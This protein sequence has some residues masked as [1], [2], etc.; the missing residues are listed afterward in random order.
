MTTKIG[1][2]TFS[3]A[4]CASGARG[5]FGEGYR[6]HRPLKPFG[7]DWR[8]STFAAKTMTLPK[9]AGNM[10]LLEDYTPKEFYP[11]CIRVNFF[12]GAPLNAVGL[13]NPGAQALLE[14]GKFQKIPRPFQLSFMAVGLTRDE[15]RKEVEGFGRLL[16]H[17]LPGF[18]SKIALQLNYSCPNL[19]GHE[20]AEEELIIEIAEDLAILGSYVDVL[21]VIKLSSATSV[22]TVLAIGSQPLCAA[23]CLGNT[24]KWCDFPD[25]LKLKYFGT[26]K[27]PLAHLG[28]GGVS[29]RPL[30]PYVLHLIGALRARGF[31]KHINACGGILSKADAWQVIHAGASSLS[32]GS[33]AFLRPLRVRGVIAY[34]N[35]MC[36]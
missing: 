13:S 27:S 33:I 11:R 22:E 30:L 4:W 6:Y 17:Y 12:G 10:P 2:I 16:A 26:L 20:T 28:G 8:H 15:R 36:L 19:E 24:I 14:C 9:R 32:L 18:R 29:G 7:L 31:A 21:F 34:A 25:Q 23:L 3:G 35:R 1:D 5:F